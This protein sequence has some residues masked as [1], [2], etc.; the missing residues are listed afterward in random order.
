VELGGGTI[1]VEGGGC[2]GSER[3]GDDWGFDSFL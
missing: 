2:G 3:G 1:E